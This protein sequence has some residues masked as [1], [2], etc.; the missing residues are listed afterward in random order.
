MKHRDMGDVSSVNTT[1]R[2]RH[3]IPMQPVTSYRPT[4][5]EVSPVVVAIGSGHWSTSGV[6][7]LL[8]PAN[9]KEE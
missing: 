9:D 5:V 3:H 4:W 2:N 8:Q 6:S 7:T 1:C